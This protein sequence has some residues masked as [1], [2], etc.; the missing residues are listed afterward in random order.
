MQ[1]ETVYKKIKNGDYF[2]AL[3]IA[4]EIYN[5]NREDVSKLVDYTTILI[6]LDKLNK[7][8]KVLKNSQFK[9]NQDPNIYFLYSQLFSAQGNIKKLREL[10]KLNPY[11]SVRTQDSNVKPLFEKRTGEKFEDYY[12]Q[13]QL[14][15]ILKNFISKYPQYS[16]QL[17]KIIIMVQNNL[18]KEG[19]KILK[20]FAFSINNKVLGYFL[21][22]EISMLEGKY[23]LAKKRYKK[24]M[25]IFPYKYIIYNRLGDIE[26]SLKNTSKAK[27]YYYKSKQLNP[28]DYNTTVD[29]IRTYLAEGELKKAKKAYIEASLKFDSEEM[30]PIKHVIENKEKCSEVDIIN[31]LAWFQGGG[32]VIK[33]EINSK[34]GNGAINMSGNIGFHLMDALKLAYTVSKY[35]YKKITKMEPHKDIFI[36]IPNNLVFVDGPSIGLAATIGILGALLKNNISQEYSF[37]GEIS[38]NGDV[39]PIGGLNWKL[40]AAYLENIKTVFIPKENLKN[41][42]QVRENIKSKLN[43]KLVSNIKEVEEY[44]WKN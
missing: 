43:I 19:K 2:D 15:Y 31:G 33:I 23:N 40:T 37:T 32:N 10:E 18:L 17:K 8:E 39:L 35:R 26:L 34:E 20:E 21:L 22:G 13:N 3:L 5:K 28:N 12:Y 4:E 9:P 6:K 11:Y 25:E 7:A 44:L 42:Y 38:L 36:N 1:I 24:I 27:T 30:L 41:L 14:I 29:I 16:H